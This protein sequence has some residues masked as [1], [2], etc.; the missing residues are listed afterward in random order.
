MLDFVSFDELGAEVSWI[1]QAAGRILEEHHLLS[2]AV[3]CH[4]E[5]SASHFLEERVRTTQSLFVSRIAGR[6]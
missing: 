3:I 6:C 5:E 4:L 1:N 2:L